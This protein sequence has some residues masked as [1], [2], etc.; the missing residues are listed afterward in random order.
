MFLWHALAAAGF[1][2]WR[3]YGIPLT[4]HF[5]WCFPQKSSPSHI[6]SG[7]II[8]KSAEVTLNGGLIRELPQNP[9]MIMVMSQIYHPRARLLN[10]VIR[11]GSARVQVP[12]VRGTLIYI[13]LFWMVVQSTPLGL[14]LKRNTYLNCIGCAILVQD[15]ELSTIYPA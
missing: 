3:L 11:N 15:L 9:D 7:Q 12:S 5:A 14:A 4:L 2:L 8:T 6:R 13:A 1:Q 10:I